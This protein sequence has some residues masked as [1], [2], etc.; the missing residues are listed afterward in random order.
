M[1]MGTSSE[2]GTI[3]HAASAV[4]SS[5]TTTS[6]GGS[7]LHKMV[8]GQ[9][10]TSGG[11]GAMQQTFVLGGMGAAG[12]G[13]GGGVI[14][15]MV[16][17]GGAAQGEGGGGGI[18]QRMA[19]SGYQEETG[20]GSGEGGIIQDLAFSAEGSLEAEYM[21]LGPDMPSTGVS[22]QWNLCPGITAASQKCAGSP[23]GCALRLHRTPSGCQLLAPGLPQL[24]KN[25]SSYIKTLPP[26]AIYVDTTDN[27][28]LKQQLP[29]Q[30]LA[31]TVCDGFS[32]VSTGKHP[33]VTDLW[34]HQQSLHN[35][36]KC[37]STYTSGSGAP[38]QQRLCYA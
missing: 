30:S 33:T 18:Q 19:Y 17:G 3:T 10:G 6:R 15:Q 28:T 1:V 29:A 2:P 26:F 24:T 27:N 20:A 31:P 23:Q 32:C 37:P 38:C 4:T 35:D 13:K 25:N 14:N 21:L 36:G 16:G 5:D 22:A 7:L 8:S 12:G 34:C 9:N 11:G